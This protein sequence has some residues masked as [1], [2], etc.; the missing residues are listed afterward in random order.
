[1]LYCENCHAP[2]PEESA[3]CPYCGAFNAL[4]GE[5]Q[6]MEQLYDLK[7]DV[8]EISEVPEQEY[9]REMG[10]IGRILFRTVLVFAGLAAVCGIGVYLFQRSTDYEISAEE[11]RVQAE[12]EREV[13]PE[14]NALYEKGDYQ[15][16]LDYV[17]AR[18]EEGRRSL[19]N[20][21]HSD[22][23]DRYMQ[24]QA[25]R[26]SLAR[27]ASGEY[28]EAEEVSCIIDALFLMQEREYDSYTEAEEAQ[29]ADYRREVKDLL[30]AKLGI[31]EAE[32]NLLYGACCVED[33]Y[34]V[35]LHYDTARKKVR[36]FVRDRNR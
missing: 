18:D 3:K 29:L 21:E 32:I 20:W 7:E 1:M 2:I 36:Q 28:D 11:V 33:D 5:R 16:V 10:K 15:G 17:Y 14:L 30:D 26:D 8:E 25:C 35:Y 4:G 27:I 24:Y 12:W 19:A 22:F 34:G 23:L 9:R 6:Y 13:F 31:A